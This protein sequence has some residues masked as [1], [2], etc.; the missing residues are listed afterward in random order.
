MYTVISK[1]FCVH[2]NRALELLSLSKLKSMQSVYGREFYY[3][4]KMTECTNQDKAIKCVWYPG[5]GTHSSNLLLYRYCQSTYINTNASNVINFSISTLASEATAATFKVVHSG[6][7]AS[8]DS[9][10]IQS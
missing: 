6:C 5:T 7:T 2:Y 10:V 8:N 9:M 1:C 4:V 3:I